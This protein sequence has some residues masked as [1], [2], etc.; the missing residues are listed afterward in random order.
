MVAA[1]G[2]NVEPLQDTRLFAACQW[3]MDCTCQQ[4]II[5]L[6]MQVFVAMQRCYIPDGTANEICLKKATRELAA[7]LGHFYPLLVFHLS[8]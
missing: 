2:W 8:N 3:T 7:H 5:E 4:E 6:Q 1:D